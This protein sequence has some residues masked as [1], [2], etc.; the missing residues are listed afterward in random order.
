MKSRSI[1]PSRR[2]LNPAGRLLNCFVCATHNR[3]V[4]FTNCSDYH[5]LS[6]LDLDM[7]AY[8]DFKLKI[9]G[10]SNFDVPETGAL[11][12]KKVEPRELLKKIEVTIHPKPQTDHD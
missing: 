12:N 1:S 8:S 10:W 2:N 4:T 7:L 6:Q 5:S 11:R 3:E 9:S